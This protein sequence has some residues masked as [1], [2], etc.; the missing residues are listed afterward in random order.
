MVQSIHIRSDNQP[1]S[2]QAAVL[3]LAGK[4]YCSFGLMNYLSK[5][6]CEFGYFISTDEENGI[7][8]FIR[9]RENL[10]QR[11]ARAYIAYDTEES[12]LVPASVFRVEEAKVHLQAGFGSH[13]DSIILSEFIKDNNLHVVYRIPG[14]LHQFISSR[15][16]YGGFSHLVSV[17]LKNG[18]QH[19]GN[20]LSLYFRSNEFVLTA[21]SDNKVICRQTYSYTSPEDVVYYLL[22]LAG[23]FHFEQY[24]TRVDLS[25]MIEKDSAVYRELF[26]YFTELH[27]EG[28]PEEMKL[29]PVLSE[30][31]SHFYSPICKLALC[32]S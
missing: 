25:G 13:A 3:I 5:T 32:V 11:F 8:A 7:E 16:Q 14:E 20:R 15:Y 23:Q 24:G 31:P 28:I 1:D 18:I 29:D 26:K 12:V 2:S 10:N 17:Q 21:F 30:H 4:T 27:F 22:K 6:I 9:N 19:P